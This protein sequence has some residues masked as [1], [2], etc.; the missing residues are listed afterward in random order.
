MKKTLF[1]WDINKPIFLS[2]CVRYIALMSLLNTFCFA[3]SYCTLIKYFFKKTYSWK[4]NVY[5]KFTCNVENKNKV[6]Y[7]K[8]PKYQSFFV[9]IWKLFKNW[10]W[11]FLNFWKTFFHS[12]DINKS[13]F[14]RIGKIFLLSTVPRLNCSWNEKKD[15]LLTYWRCVGFRH[16]CGTSKKEEKKKEKKRRKTACFNSFLTKNS[17]NGISGIAQKI[18]TWNKKLSIVILCV[19][20]AE[21]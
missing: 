18:F 7:I 17:S 2:F 10:K 19:V 20:T 4:K 1:K 6:K 13:L 14:P 8:F 12:R 21:L 15:F 5:T 11:P 3:Y 9:F 16:C